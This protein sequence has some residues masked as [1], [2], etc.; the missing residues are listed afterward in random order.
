MADADI[1]RKYP[2]L[3]FLLSDP[4]VG[5]LLR[6]ADSTN[7]DPDVFQSRLMQTTWWKT[8]SDTQRNFYALKTGDPATYSRRQEEVKS[9]IREIGGALGYGA[10]VLDE[11]YLNFFAD[12]ALQ[13]GMSTRQ[14]Q[15]MIADE[16]TPLIG[17]SEKG[18]TLRDLRAVQQNYSYIVDDP[19]F[20]HWSKEINAGRQTIENF[21]NSVRQQM[22]G[23]FPNL[24]GQLDSG[25]TFKQIID[26]Y[27]QIL[28]KE[29]DGRSLEDFDFMG[30]P[31]W[32]HVIDYVDEKTGVHR[33][34]SMVELT[35]YA[36]S[37]PEWRNTNNAKQQ[38]A[39]LGEQ[40]LES[41][42]A[43]G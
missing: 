11:G 4:E 33:T 5:P 14:I 35:K 22:K 26:P 17:A 28:S 18:N 36:R 32:R 42:G 1:T 21:E 10:D 9:Q 19:T 27:R 2:Y 8:N 3:S 12:K 24:A 30:D 34:M 43:L 38:A 29:F 37:Q 20:L 31:K 25:M 7:M 13:Y 40:L 16:I 39:Q 6:E 23:L 41:F 15:A